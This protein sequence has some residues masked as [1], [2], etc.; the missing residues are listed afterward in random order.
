MTIKQAL[1]CLL[2]FTITAQAIDFSAEHPWNKTHAALVCQKNLDSLPHQNN[3]RS[4]W[5]LE[6]YAINLYKEI[7]NPVARRKRELAFNVF[8]SIEAAHGTAGLANKENEQVWHDLTLLCG[9]T[10]QEHYVAKT[11]FP[12]ITQVGIA[13]TCLMLTKPTTNPTALEQQQ[14]LINTIATSTPLRTALEQTLHDFAKHEHVLIN[15]WDETDHLDSSIHRTVYFNKK[16]FDFLNTNE[17]VL[18]LKGTAFLGGMYTQC[19][20]QM[21][22]CCILG[23]YGCYKLT[24]ANTPEPLENGA[25]RYFGNAGAIMSTLH[26]I[27]QPT[28]QGLVALAASAMCGYYAVD[29]YTDQIRGIRAYLNTMCKLTQQMALTMRS[30][31]ELINTLDKHSLLNDPTCKT[32]KLVHSSIAMQQFFQL[33]QQAC[34]DTEDAAVSLRN[35]GMVLAFLKHFFNYKP[36][37]QAAITKLGYI[38][39][40]TACAKNIVDQPDRWCVPAF[41]KNDTPYI[42]ADNF[43]HPLIKGNAITSSLTLGTDGNRPH[44]VITGP[45]EGGKSTT[46]KAVA[47]AALC[48]QTVGICPAKSFAMTPFAYIKTYLNIN[49]DI[50][51]GNS[52]FR[53]EFKRAQ[54]LVDTISTAKPGEFGL[55]VFDEMC[56]GTSPVEGAAAAYIIAKRLSNFNNCLCLVATHFANMTN[57]EFDTTTFKNYNVRAIQRDDGSF[58]YPRILEEGPSNQHIALDILRNEGFAGSLIDEARDMVRSMTLTM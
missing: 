6:E 1:L 13:N 20:M 10:N 9:Q 48:G 39:T 51:A 28:I 55:F 31:N 11:A 25:N 30:L 37:I 35:M 47:L 42:V 3:G 23:I 41:V 43:W 4:S 19:A 53:A 50:G 27:D 57:L 49:D 44:A 12:T 36:I 38:D 21:A 16:H 58:T 34:F 14:R 26:M 24:Q 18:Q 5:S 7:T 52:L 45:N 22:A 2:A 32:F 17:S 46:M 8:K 29:G 33:A 56:S 40:M 54:E 15:F